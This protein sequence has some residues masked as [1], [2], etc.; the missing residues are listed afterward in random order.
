MRM[1][2]GGKP[3]GGEDLVGKIP[4]REETRRGNTGEK[5]LGGK[6][7]SRDIQ[8]K[9]QVYLLKKKDFV[10]SGELKSWE[11]S[12]LYPPSPLSWI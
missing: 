8:A 4:K 7:R 10:K 11:K 9:I 3:Q 1:D 12:C 2:R 5:R 6:N